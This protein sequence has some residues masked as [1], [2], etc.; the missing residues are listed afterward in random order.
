[1]CCAIAGG[2]EELDAPTGSRVCQVASPIITLLSVD[3]IVNICMQSMR[4]V[5]GVSW[6][7]LGWRLENL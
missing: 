2:R 1:M 3:N 6:W 7:L 4:H 5:V